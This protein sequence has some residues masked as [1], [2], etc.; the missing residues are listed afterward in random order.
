MTVRTVLKLP[1][2]KAAP[3]AWPSDVPASLAS[4]ANAWTRDRNFGSLVPVQTLPIFMAS[5]AQKL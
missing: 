4:D 3:P 5:Q 1:F 2:E